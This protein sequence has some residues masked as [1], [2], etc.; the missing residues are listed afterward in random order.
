MRQRSDIAEVASKHRGRLDVRSSSVHLTDVTSK[1][2][3]RLD[4]RDYTV[5]LHVDSP[6]RS[7]YDHVMNPQ[8]LCLAPMSS[9]IM[10]PKHKQEY[11]PQQISSSGI[12]VYNRNERSN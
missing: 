5:D 9:A 8:P 1:Y 11:V 7:F 12:T 4:I 3:V 10:P 2:R 6:L